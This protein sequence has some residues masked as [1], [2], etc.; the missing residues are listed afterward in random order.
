MILFK[1]EYKISYIMIALCLTRGNRLLWV[2]LKNGDF[3]VLMM[4]H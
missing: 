3:V 2:C 1:L 4:I